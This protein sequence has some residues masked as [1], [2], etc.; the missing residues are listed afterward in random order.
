MHSAALVKAPNRDWN[1]GWAALYY[2]FPD[3]RSRP[4]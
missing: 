4:D 3:F 2:L 1:T